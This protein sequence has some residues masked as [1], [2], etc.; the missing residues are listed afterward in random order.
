[1][2]NAWFTQKRIVVIFA[3]ALVLPLLG[4]SRAVAGEKD[5][6]ARENAAF[7]DGA[8][9]WTSVFVS[10]RFSELKKT[11]YMR[12]AF[13][14]DAK[15]RLEYWRKL[16]DS[17]KKTCSIALEEYDSAELFFG[18]EDADT[19]TPCGALRM[20]S[21]KPFDAEH[22][23]KTGKM[24]K[25]KDYK[26]Y[27]VGT[28]LF[29]NL[30]CFFPDDRTVIFFPVD[31]PKPIFDASWK[32]DDKHLLSDSLKL[33]RKKEYPIVVA[34]KLN[35]F[36]PENTP[37]K[38]ANFYQADSV[39]ITVKVADELH[40]DVLLRFSKIQRSKK[41]ALQETLEYL[42]EE[43]DK[44]QEDEKKD[45]PQTAVF[46]DK[47]SDALKKAKV[48]QEGRVQHAPLIIKIPPKTLGDTIEESCKALAGLRLH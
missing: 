42:A 18:T 37:K 29:F 46:Q 25:Y 27:D 38:L 21:S 34:W 48:R 3:L 39:T 31:G 36:V 11:D 40:V 41:K 23:L 28:F 10:I 32:I 14:P 4:V 22:P 26:V 12:K 2:K 35:D 7:V 5:K 8:P 15:R 45:R 20:K 17:I 13:T 33:S 44:N 1:M 30:A 16:L 6:R 43:F 47:I 9:E 19:R 24:S